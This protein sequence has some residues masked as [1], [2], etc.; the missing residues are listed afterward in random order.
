MTT[1]TATQPQEIWFITPV[2]GHKYWDFFTRY[3][4]PSLLTY[5]NIGAL[6]GPK[7]RYVI[8]TL[9]EDLEA[10]KNNVCLNELFRQVNVAFIY[11]TK[12]MLDQYQNK[13]YIVMSRCHSHALAEARNVDAGFF[14]LFPDTIISDGSI[15]YSMEMCA[16]GYR[17][18]MVS[19]FRAIKEK[20]C[21]ALEA[22]R[23]SDR[24]GTLSMNPR[25]LARLAIDHMHPITLAHMQKGDRVRMFGRH[26]WP[27]EDW[28]ILERTYHPGPFFF[29]PTIKTD[30]IHSTL[31]HD[32]VKLGV[33]DKSKVHVVTDSDNLF[34]CEA[35]DASY[36][37]A[38][39]PTKPQ[40][41]DELADWALNWT[42]DFHRDFI[43]ERIVVRTKAGDIPE[44]I[45]IESDTIIDRY[46]SYLEKVNGHL[47]TDFVQGE[48]RL[49][50]TG[51]IDLFSVLNKNQEYATAWDLAVRI[52]QLYETIGRRLFLVQWLQAVQFHTNKADVAAKLFCFDAVT[53]LLHKEYNILSGFEGTFEKENYRNVNAD[54]LRHTQKAY[55]SN[56]AFRAPRHPDFFQQAEK[57]FLAELANVHT[58]ETWLQELG[59]IHL[60]LDWGKM[61]EAEQRLNKI[62]DDTGLGSFLAD[63]GNQAFYPD[64]LVLAAWLKFQVHRDQEPSSPIWRSLTL[65]KLITWY[66]DAVNYHPFELICAYLGR[67]AYRYGTPEDRPQDFFYHAMSMPRTGNLNKSCHSHAI[68]A[69][70]QTWWAII[71]HEAGRSESAGFKMGRVLSFLEAVSYKEE[72]ASMLQTQEGRAVGGWFA[73][74]WEALR[75]VDWSTGFSMDACRRFLECFTFTYH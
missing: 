37:V 32:L 41:I 60:Y 18:V 48:R 59:L 69:Q 4:L 21:P 49:Q 58:R 5:N 10:F 12:E 35:S 65:D 23:Q 42:N 27:L 8:M 50:I 22:Y 16:A 2:W 31:D 62:T 64:P 61:E 46:T 55:G 6:R 73:E 44:P 30:Q 47:L 38:T 51:M 56:L 71:D 74:A 11:I 40:S 14:F 1:E 53:E 26:Y 17:A 67:L 36:Q 72:L 7:V 43:R 13:S 70:I 3:C 34:V 66:E 39:I 63:P 75:A 57:V 68:K 28:G 15:R 25:D 45:R 9:K 33:P 54:P 20:I 24:L 19:G 29:W 52:E